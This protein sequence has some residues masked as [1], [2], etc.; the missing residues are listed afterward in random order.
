MGEDIVNIL[1]VGVIDTTAGAGTMY[2]QIGS[3]DPVYFSPGDSREILAVMEAAKVYVS[4][5]LKTS[6]M[7]AHAAFAEMLGG[8]GSPIV[9]E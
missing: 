9:V 2:I 7:E 8:G 6:S 3:N 5:R 4:E 1:K